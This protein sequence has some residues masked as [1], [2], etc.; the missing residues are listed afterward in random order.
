MRDARNAVKDYD[1][2]LQLLEG[3]TA[4]M[5]AALK[6]ASTAKNGSP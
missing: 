3:S 6:S 4:A 2:K 5:T 1:L